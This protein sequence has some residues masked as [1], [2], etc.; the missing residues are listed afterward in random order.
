MKITKIIAS[1]S[2]EDILNA[3][4]EIL[5]KS[6]YIPK[7]TFTIKDLGPIL[8]GDI[9]LEVIQ[10][11]QKNQLLSLENVIFPEEFFV[12]LC[13]KCQNLS[14]FIVN[15]SEE[16]IQ[17]SANRVLKNMKKDSQEL[18]IKA[19]ISNKNLD[20]KY[21]SLKKI[22]GELEYQKISETLLNLYSDFGH[23]MYLDLRSQINTLPLKFQR[24]RKE[25]LDI[26]LVDLG[27]SV[28][29]L[30]CLKAADHVKFKDVI[31]VPF[32]I[33]GKYRNFGQKSFQEIL[34]LKDMYKIQ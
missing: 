30:N 14:V 20:K 21:L 1:I 26:P 5:K 19:F 24:E 7:E 8:K 13:G 4:K 15:I 25:V 34:D 9:S 12:R 18:L 33:L 11:D 17:E 22:F 2:Q 27:M 3:V 10:E 6:G 32:E 31:S 28:R 23:K 29:S 16:K